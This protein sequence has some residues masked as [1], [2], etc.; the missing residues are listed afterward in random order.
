[1]KVIKIIIHLLLERKEIQLHLQ[2]FKVV[3]QVKEKNYFKNN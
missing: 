3:F 2:E 1:M